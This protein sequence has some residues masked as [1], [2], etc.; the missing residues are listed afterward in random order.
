MLPISLY[1]NLDLCLLQFKNPK[2]V[3]NF[4]LYFFGESNY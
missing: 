2:K 1:G 3:N 4:I